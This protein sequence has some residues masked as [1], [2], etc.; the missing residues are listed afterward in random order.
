[1]HRGLALYPRKVAIAGKSS[2][3]MVYSVGYLTKRAI[4]HDPWS[5]ISKKK[6]GPFGGIVEG[7]KFLICI[8][9]AT[10]SY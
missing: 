7:L 9:F 8:I 4:N 5:Y 2:S 1:M 10:F 6:R 3:T